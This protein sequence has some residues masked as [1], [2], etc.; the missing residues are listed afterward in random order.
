MSATNPPITTTV[1]TAA[2]RQIPVSFITFNII[3]FVDVV[4]HS[5]PS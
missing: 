1:A 2:K 3:Y 4:E 5:G